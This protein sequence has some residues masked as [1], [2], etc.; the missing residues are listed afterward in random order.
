MHD[1][2]IALVIREDLKPWQKLNVAAFLASAITIDCEE[3][4]GHALISASRTS[5]LPFIKQ[6]ILIYK[7]DHLDEL[8][9]LLKRGKERELKIGIYTEP[10]FATKSATE[11]LA[12]IS[13]NF[14][15]DLD[16]VGIA[17]YGETKKVNKTIE[18]LKLHP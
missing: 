8:K 9:K 3:T 5:Y 14:D 17:L 7:A 4:H 1:K 13:K 10:L 12:E 15:E 2:K 11:N 6:P 16:L 18:G